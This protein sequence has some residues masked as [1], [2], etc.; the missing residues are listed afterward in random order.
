MSITIADKNKAYISFFFLINGGTH[1][2]KG[3]TKLA[4]QAQYQ[5]GEIMKGKNTKDHFMTCIYRDSVHY[6]LHI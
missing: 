1:K 3:T 4:V 5:T 2:H 6:V